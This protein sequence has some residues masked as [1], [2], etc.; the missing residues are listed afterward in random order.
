MFLAEEY[1]VG[2]RDTKMASNEP[3]YLG[4]V[5]SKSVDKLLCLCE[6]GQSWNHVPVIVES[7]SFGDLLP[8]RYWNG[9]LRHDCLSS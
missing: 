4:S 6:C 1:K 5:R 9:E 2:N 7:L 8:F 3:F